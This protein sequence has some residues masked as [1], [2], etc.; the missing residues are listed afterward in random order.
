MNSPTDSYRFETLLRPHLDRLYRF[1]FRLTGSKVEAEDLFQDVLTKMVARVDSLAAID[2]PGS[3][4][5]R[6]MYNHFIDNR[7][8]F[9]RRRLVSVGEDQI[10][11]GSLDGVAGDLDPVADGERRDKVQ[12]LHAALEA[13]SEEH[14]LVLMLHDVEEYKLQEIQDITGTPMG[15][16]KSRLHR[17]RNRLR[18]IL[19]ADG[20]FAAE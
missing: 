2:E 12:Q 6:I 9:A 16:L 20:T 10:P 11:G 3:W 5:C 15:T 1:A 7:R 18:E 14:R 8:R 19:L 4:L 17:G 13:L